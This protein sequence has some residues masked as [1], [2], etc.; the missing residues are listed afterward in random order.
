[1]DLWVCT[2]VSLSIGLFWILISGILAFINMIHSS[3]S[4]N[5]SGSIGIYLWNSIAGNKIKKRNKKFQIIN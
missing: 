5:L 4:S 1:M 3:N 2:I